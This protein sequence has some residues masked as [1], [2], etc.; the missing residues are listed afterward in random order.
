MGRPAEGEDRGAGGG[1]RGPPRRGRH[2]GLAV[3]VE[4]AQT[5]AAGGRARRRAG[6]ERREARRDRPDRQVRLCSWLRGVPA[7]RYRARQVLVARRR[8]RPARRGSRQRFAQLGPEQAGDRRLGGG[9]AVRGARTAWSRSAAGRTGSSSSSRTSSPGGNSATCPS[10]SAEP[11]WSVACRRPR[12]DASAAG[13]G[14][15]HARRRVPR[16]DGVPG[17]RRPGA[18]AA[19][20]RRR[21]RRRGPGDVAPRVRGLEPPPGRARPREPRAASSISGPGS[22]AKTSSWPAGA[23]CRPCSSRRS[24]GRDRR[25]SEQKAPRSSWP[26]AHRSRPPR[27]TRANVARQGRVT[28]A[29]MGAIHPLAW[30]RRPWRSISRRGSLGRLDRIAGLRARIRSS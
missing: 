14:H 11:G 3:V 6:H 4:I 12:A 20:L 7:A 2:R 28:L 15:A 16:N 8:A 13:G 25:C 1:G 5:A 26:R 9:R 30:P 24:P 19:C 29:R 23:G 10:S 21:L 18:D 22:S 27:P 17:R